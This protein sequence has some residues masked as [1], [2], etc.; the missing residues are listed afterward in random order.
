MPLLDAVKNLGTS[1]TVAKVK[2]ATDENRNA[3]VST[4]LIT[5]IC[6]LTYTPNTLR[7]IIQLLRKRLINNSKKNSHKSTV[8]LLKT[9]TLITFLV[10]NGSEE[11]VSWL[12]ESLVLIESLQT[13]STTDKN[14]QKMIEHIQTLSKKLCSVLKDP[15]LLAK[16]KEDLNMFKLSISTPGRKSTDSVHLNPVG[17]VRNSITSSKNDTGSPICPSPTGSPKSDGHSF[18]RPSRPSV[19]KSGYKYSFDQSNHKFQLDALAEEDT[20]EDLITTGVPSTA[21][22]FSP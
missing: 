19:M 22:R 4:S 11:F 13:F 6:V 9:I 17:Q 16:R 12:K 20:R 8:R 7:E 15:N 5:Q 2:T 18:H 21:S 1:S 14:D 3:G 10:S